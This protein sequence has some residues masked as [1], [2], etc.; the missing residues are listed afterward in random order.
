MPAATLSRVN[1]VLTRRPIEARFATIWY[2]VL[3]SVGC[4]THCNAGH[5]P[6][7][8]VGNCGSQRLARASLIVG[9]FSQVNFEEET[10][11]LDPGDLLV[12]FSDGLT[13]ALNT[14]GEE[15]GEE[16][17]LSCVNA[18]LEL[19]PVALLECLLDTVHQ[20]TTGAVQTDDL[21][22]LVLR[23]VGT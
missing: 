20:F 17:V 1:D 18:N 10:I 23:Y 12:V 16:R 5:N 14:D 2:G 3:S 11:Q 7:L 22:L 8:L 9:A 13:E 21:T 4:L 6:P 15:F 19:P